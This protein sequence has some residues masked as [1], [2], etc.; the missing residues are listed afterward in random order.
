MI[1]GGVFRDILPSIQ[2][3]AREILGHQWMAVSRTF[4]YLFLYSSLLI[5]FFQSFVILKKSS[6]KEDCSYLYQILFKLRFILGGYLFIALT[7]LCFW[8]S[9]S[10]Q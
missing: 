5:L 3:E 10:P 8:L 2:V 4:F 7:A 9:T 1:Y 6:S